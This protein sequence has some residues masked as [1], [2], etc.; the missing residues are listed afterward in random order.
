MAPRERIEDRLIGELDRLIQKLPTYGPL[1]DVLRSCQIE[2]KGQD[3]WRLSAIMVVQLCWALTKLPRPK[4]SKW[5]AD[6]DL[7]LEVQMIGL[8]YGPEG[9]SERRAIKKLAATWDF[10]YT[11][12]AGRKSPKTDAKAQRE[13][14]LRQRWKDL[15]HRSSL[16]DATLRFGAGGENLSASD[17]LQFPNFAG[18]SALRRRKSA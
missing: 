3:A 14:A 12:Q 16:L 17:P 15:K 8:C 4:S 7:A 9:L 5:T 1:A 11:P 6:T 10:P 2:P 13:Q 18:D